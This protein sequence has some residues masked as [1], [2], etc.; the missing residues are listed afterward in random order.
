MPGLQARTAWSHAAKGV[1]ELAEVSS[2]RAV[3]SSL[4]GFRGRCP[5]PSGAPLPESGAVGQVGPGSG[6]AAAA[7]HVHR[8]STEQSREKGTVTW[9]P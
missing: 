2:S 5:L 9:S 1:T 4:T 6:A 3:A 7:V 8:E